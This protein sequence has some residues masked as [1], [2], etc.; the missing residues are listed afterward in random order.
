M[1]TK[2]APKRQAHHVHSVAG[3]VLGQQVEH[4]G[5]DCKAGKA[6]LVGFS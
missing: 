6:Q 4:S 2:L 5:A 3:A 1:L